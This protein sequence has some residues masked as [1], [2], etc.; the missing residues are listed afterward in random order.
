MERSDAILL[1]SFSHNELLGWVNDTKLVLASFERSIG[2]TAKRDGEFETP[3]LNAFFP[4]TR[5]AMGNWANS[6]FLYHQLDGFTIEEN[7]FDKQNLG[8][9]LSTNITVPA[10]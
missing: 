3:V 7:E 9:I 5:L 10:A 6:S 8:W 1:P 2:T 4:Y